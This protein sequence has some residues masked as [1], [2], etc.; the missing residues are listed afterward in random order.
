VEGLV[1]RELYAALWRLMISELR[2]GG[3]ERAPLRTQ[4]AGDAVESPHQLVEAGKQIIRRMTPF[5]TRWLRIARSWWCGIES[6]YLRMSTSSTQC[7]RRTVMT[8]DR[9]RSAWCAERP[10]RNPYEQDRKSSGHDSKLN[11]ALARKG[12]P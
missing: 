1:N 2:R 8:P 12:L 9:C 3:G 4:V 6:K 10:G 5:V 11:E 7:C